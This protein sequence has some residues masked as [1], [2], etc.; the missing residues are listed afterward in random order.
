VKFA[1]STLVLLA[2]GCGLLIS[3][4]HAFTKNT[5]TQNEQQYAAN[6]IRS[7]SGNVHENI[8]QLDDDLYFSEGE[9]IVTGFI[10][11]QSTKQGYN[12]NISAWIAIDQTQK[13]RGIRVYEHKE[14]PG[15]GDKID[16]QVSDWIRRFT[17]ATL[18]G[19]S[20]SITK[21]GGE[22]DH[23]TGATITS[24][25]MVH[26]VHAGLI[27]AQNNTMEWTM[28]LEKHYEQR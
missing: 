21:D 27:R 10:F 5:I 15:I 9:G 26:S 14:T 4:L 18:A 24:R 22:F 8:I 3:T 16:S 7:V 28:M 6:Q 25:A 23:F 17:G 2:G 20:W 12:G 11:S 1:I 19:N 13:I